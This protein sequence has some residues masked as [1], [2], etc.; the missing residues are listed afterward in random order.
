MAAAGSFRYPRRSVVGV[1]RTSRDVRSSLS[2]GKR[3]WRL[4][5][6]TS[7]FDPTA[8]LATRSAAS[9]RKVAFRI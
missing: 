7:E 4:R 1:K 6:P 3:T 5:A 8:T 9:Q 2:G